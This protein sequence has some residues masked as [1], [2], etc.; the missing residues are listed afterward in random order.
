MAIIDT[1]TSLPQLPCNKTIL[2]VC[3]NS[4]HLRWGMV[5]RINDLF[6]IDPI[7]NLEIK[8][9]IEKITYNGGNIEATL[10]L[11]E[12]IDAFLSVGGTITFHGDRTL[13]FHAER[14]ITG[15]NIIDGMIFWTD[16][17]SEPKKVNIERGKIGS[18]SHAYGAGY[19]GSQT[20]ER[21]TWDGKTNTFLP[22]NN[23]AYY[24]D[25]DQHTKLIIDE[26]TVTEC[27]KSTLF[28]PVLGCTN[29]LATNYNPLANID[30]GS[31]TVPPVPGCTDVTA[32]NYD[33]LANSDDGSCTYL[34]CT[35]PLAT[36]YDATA[37]CD[38][39]SC[40][41]EATDNDFE[42]EIG[43]VTYGC[44]DSTATNYDA[45]A[46][47]D[48]GSCI[49][50][51]GFYEGGLIFWLDG[52][53]GGLV[54][55]AVDQSTG[56]QWGCQ[57]TNLPGANNHGI[58]NPGG[59]KNTYDILAGCAD[60][61]TAAEICDNL[62]LNGYNDWFLPSGSELAAMANNIGPI[63][64]ANIGNFNTTGQVKYWS[65][66]E[67]SQTNPVTGVS[68]ATSAVSHRFGLNQMNIVWKGIYH[69]VRAVR[70]FYGPQGPPAPNTII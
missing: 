35:N 50:P 46:T 55:A 26:N 17:Y 7:T 27:E 18:T 59:A 45:N 20:Q 8:A 69:Y 54:A 40:L 31:C 6:P 24:S 47:I 56:V 11:S 28:C 60:S 70:R 10:T 57:G 38:D 12:N 9:Y 34:G 67:T 25:F 51:I 62:S 66:S 30:D 61:P 64:G 63:S 3:K 19:D 32:C 22:I 33:A 68:P 16:N 5:L 41:L 44:T 36:N 1:T 39:G 15:V 2:K 23:F 4:M 58:A 48:D 53:G 49:F 42:I 65:S 14:N 52:D 13:S 43:G 29:P 21:T 37:G